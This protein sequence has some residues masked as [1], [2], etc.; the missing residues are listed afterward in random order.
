MTL[1]RRTLLGLLALAAA[2]S[3]RLIWQSGE[4]FISIPKPGAFNRTTPPILAD[5]FALHMETL[6]PTLLPRCCAKQSDQ[7]LP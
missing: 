6:M 5:V 2:D 1:T 4:K 3:E 7:E